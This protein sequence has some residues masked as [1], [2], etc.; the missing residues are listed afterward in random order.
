VRRTSAGFDPP[1]TSRGSD[2]HKGRP[3]GGRGDDYR[4]TD[5]PVREQSPVPAQVV[6]PAPVSAPAPQRAPAAAAVPAPVTEAA[7]TAPPDQAT[8]PP[9]A[10][11]EPPVPVWPA[12]P[13]SNSGPGNA[14]DRPDGSGDQKSGGSSGTSGSRR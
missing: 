11:V 14:E 5:R 9:P 2:G 12:K 13:P 7:P 10:V 6:A 8:S 3:W 1:P 4:D